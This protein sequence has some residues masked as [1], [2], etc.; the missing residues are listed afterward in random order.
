V[1]AS[2]Q[3]CQKK[4]RTPRNPHNEA[5]PAS[6]QKRA[7]IVGFIRKPPFYRSATS[8]FPVRS[9]VKKGQVSQAALDVLI[10]QGRHCKLPVP[11]M[12]SRST[13]PATRTASSTTGECFRAS[14]R[15]SSTFVEWTA[16][17]V[18]SK[19]FAKKQQ[20]QWTPRRAHLLLE[21]RKMAEPPHD[22]A[23]RTRHGTKA[24]VSQ[25]QVERGPLWSFGALAR[26]RN[27]RFRDPWEAL[28]G[29][30][31]SRFAFNW[32]SGV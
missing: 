16:N 9:S 28:R 31:D 30:S 26:G 3:S 7:R 20:M 13:L 22:R 18:V 12:N 8:L 2:I 27:G 23:S 14:E 10:S 5:S 6:T 21:V 15:I 29:K 11:R 4:L 24:K 25:T 1:S 32:A 19:R 17:T